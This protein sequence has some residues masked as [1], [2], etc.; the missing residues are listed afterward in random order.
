MNPL[1][2]LAKETAVYG[3]SSIV[4]RLLNYFLVPLYTRIFLPGEYGIVTELY[5]YASF[6]MVL[7]TFGMETTYFRFSQNRPEEGRVY[8]TALAPI[9]GLNL[10][11]MLLGI[12]SSPF[13]ARQL[14]YGNHADYLVCFV[15][16]VGLDAITAVP[17]ARLRQ[18]HQALRFALLKLTGI[19]VNIALNLFFLLLCPWLLG[20]GFAGIGAI[21]D[22]S[23]GVGYVFLANLVSSALVLLLLSGDMIRSGMALDRKLLGEMLRYASPL[24]LAGLAGMVNETLDRILLRYLLVVPAGIADAGGYVMSQIGIYGANY[25]V[26]ILMTLFIQTFRYA[27]EPFFFSHAAETDSRRLYGRVM[28]WFV[29]FGLIIF[30]GIMLHLGLIRDFIG[31]KY[32]AGL[33]IVPILLLANLCLGVIFNLSIWYKLNGMTHYGAS[34]TIFGALVTVAANCILIPRMGYA[35]AA[36]ATLICYVLMMILSYVWGQKHYRIQYDLPRMGGYLLLALALFAASALVRLPSPLAA[37]ALNSALFAA[38][39][40]VAVWREKPGRLRS[41]PPVQGQP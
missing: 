35:G 5:A 17:F 2:R 18:R 30:L 40:G 32:H 8:G 14:H 12:V 4:G 6:L 41:R 1:K 39:V 26:S 36:W 31:A 13:L 10:L 28:T 9:L 34:I 33:G 27:A 38:F 22:P 15:L 24:L 16:I 20:H 25:K 3:L 19:G 37:Q 7:L 21:Y 23:W 11:F 29:L